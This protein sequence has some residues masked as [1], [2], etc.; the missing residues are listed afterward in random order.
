MRL[1]IMV[2]LSM[3]FLSGGLNKRISEVVINGKGAA[4]WEFAPKGISP[5]I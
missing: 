2:G 4:N 3:T 1:P 5:T